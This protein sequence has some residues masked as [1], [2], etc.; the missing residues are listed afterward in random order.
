MSIGTR[1]GF[2]VKRIICLHSDLTR[3]YNL[4]VQDPDSV[5]EWLSQGIT[6]LIP[7]NDKTDQA[8]NYRPIT[9]LS[10]FYKTLTSVIKQRIEGHLIQGNLM[11]SEQKG[12]QQ[13]SF[14]AKDHL[15][16]NK[17]LTEDCKASH[18]SLSM[19]W[20]DYQKAYDSVPHSWVLQC[21]QLHKISP[22]LCRFLSRVMEGWRTSMVHS[23]G[24]GTVKTRIMQIRRGIFQGDSLAPLLFCMAL[25]PLSTELNRTGCGK[26]YDSVPHSWVL[27]CLQLHKISPVLCRFL[28]RVMEGWRTSMVHSHGQGTVKTRIMQIRRGIFQGDSLAPLLF[29]MALNPLSTELN[30]TGCGCRMS[31]GNGRTA[32]R[33]LISHL[34]Y[35]DDLKLYG[36]NPD[37]LDG[38]LHAVRT[39]SDDIRMKFGLDKCAI[40]HFVNGKL[41]GHNTGV[42]VGK[43]ETIKGLEPGQVYKYL[44]VDESNGIQHSTMRERV[45][46]E[47]FHRVKM[48]LRT[49]LYGRNK[50][51]AIN[52][53]ALPVLTYSFGVIHWGT[54]EQLDR[55]TRKLLTMHGVHHPSADVDRLYAP[56]NEGGRGLQQIEA[57][58]KSCIVGLECYLRDSNYPYMQLVYECDSGRSRYSIKSMACRFTAQLRRDLAKDDTS[59][60]LHG[61]GTVASDGVFE[62][63]PQMDAKHF[64]M[65]NSSLRVR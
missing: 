9:C 56:C 27:Q 35:M 62:Q 55:R 2:W 21:L 31:M 52:G 3:N 16:I 11:A 14:G 7:K 44:G 23:H 6:T 18:R 46:R 47:Y 48:V 65:C 39:F 61:S 17:L 36:R 25:N 41:S 19:A 4:L 20:V 63:A 37:Q 51:L 34:L 49:E 38:L 5:P 13:G 50:V 26:A 42:K 32:K 43:T 29:C 64:R 15:L 58:Y 60:S 45:R 12:C 57:M 22:V 24:Q 10:V 53:L 54:T 30:R 1:S 8:K 40:A 28:S 33:Q 59:Q